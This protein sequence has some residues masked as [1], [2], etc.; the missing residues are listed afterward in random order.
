VLVAA[1]AEGNTIGGTAAGAGNVL[2]GVTDDVGV[3]LKDAN[4]EFN[5]IA[6]NYFGTDSTGT[7][8]SNAFIYDILVESN[9]QHNTIGGTAAG[10]RNL[11]DA[12]VIGVLAFASYTTIE[13]NYIGVDATGSHSIANRGGV[14]VGGFDD[15]ISGNVI[16]GNQN[17]GVA[18]DGSAYAMVQGNRIGT[19]A[20][21]TGVLANGLGIEALAGANNNTIGGTSAAA[22]NTISG[23]TGDGVLLTGSGTTANTVEGDFISTDV[24]GRSSLANGTNGVEVTAG[25]SG[26]TI[27]GVAQGVTSILTAGDSFT[28]VY[29]V[30]IANNGDL[31]VADPYNADLVRVNSQTGAQTVISSGGNFH[32]AGR[33]CPR[34]EW[35]HLRC[36]LRGSAWWWRT[37]H[38]RELDHGRPDGYRLQRRLDQS[39]RPD[40]RAGRQSLR[41][42]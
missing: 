19:N 28:D 37:N 26:N 17:Y 22:R 3:Y 34:H 20:T 30:A 5:I 9:A 35:R 12:S 41:R 14:D 38:S 11:I 36:R 13:G 23:N 18:L 4:T 42:R 33:S 25:A 7:H 40:V 39:N 8:Y 10:A 15:P 21:G 31:I 6:G 32:L 27:G 29:G 2:A 1:G 16:S 24:T